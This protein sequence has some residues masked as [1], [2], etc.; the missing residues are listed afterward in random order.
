MKIDNITV[1]TKV[2]FTGSN[3]R[4]GNPVKGIVKKITDQ[5]IEVE[6]LENIKLISIDFEKGETTSFQLSN[7]NDV[8][9]V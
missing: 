8:K 1:L 9:I 4:Y 7:I 2:E 6:L 3:V 5:W